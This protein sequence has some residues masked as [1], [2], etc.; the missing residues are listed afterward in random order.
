MYQTAGLNILYNYNKT[1]LILCAFWSGE[2]AMGY[3]ASK[4]TQ[5]SERETATYNNL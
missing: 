4:L 5:N 2:K 1:T 3:C